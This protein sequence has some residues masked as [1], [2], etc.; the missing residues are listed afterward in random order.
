MKRKY[1][2][3]PLLAGAVIMSACKDKSTTDTQ[4]SS[5]SDSSTGSSATAPAVPAPDPIK[6]SATPEKRAEK[7]GFAKHLPKTIVKYDGIF[8]GKEAFQEFLKTPIGAFVLQRMADEGVSLEELMESGPAAGQIAQY[9]EEYF[10]AYGSGTGETFDLAM[11]L[12]NRFAYYGGRTGVHMADGF[13]REGDAYQPRGPEE[14][15]NGPLKGAPKEIV[16]MFQSFNMPAVYQGAK[17]SDAEA[18]ELVVEQMEQITSLFGMVE[19]I[20]EAITIKRGE[21][22]FNGFKISGAKIAE[23]IDEDDMEEMQEVFEAEDVSAFRDAL[24]KKSIICV[25]GTVGDYV[26]LF[27]GKSEDDFVL[28]ESVSDSMCANEE[29][30]FLDTYLDKKIIS[31]GYSDSKVVEM[32]GNLEAVGFRLLNS[33]TKGLGD[34]L[35]DAGSLGDT[36]DIEALLGSITEQGEKLVGMFN[37]ADL[38]YVVYIEDGLK[39]EGFG[40][41]NMPSI[42]FSKEHSL[43]SLGDGDNTLLFA[44]WTSN[45]AYNEA[46]MEYIDSVGE[47]AYLLTKRVA[48]LDIDDGDFRDFKQGVEMFDKAFQSDAVELWKALRGD[49]AAGLGAESALVMDVNGALPKIPNVPDVILKEG[50]MPRIGYVSTVDDRAKLQSSW[51][52]VNTSAENIL[53]TISEM[54]GE[55]IPMQV[56]MSSEKDGLKTWFVPIPFQN[57]D[58]VPSVSVSDEL[59]FVSTSKTFSEGLAERFKTGSKSGRK[60]AWLHVDFKVLNGFAKQWLALVEKNVE[61]IIPN[62]SGRADFTENKPMIDEALKVFGSLDTLTLN[63]RKE[64]GRTRVSLHLKT[65]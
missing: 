62:E 48:A 37:A 65:Q 19:E 46:V 14:F 50:K 17:V 57:D 21:N 35:G 60:G 36:Q 12:L 3:V 53:K 18:R 40:G 16:K 9:S 10:T 11:N 7:L 43:A 64:G 30:V 47:T 2:L 49:L 24:S 44:N 20:S 51:T 27:L 6:P 31:L 23:E 38:G 42:D 26:I 5:T 1:F 25:S 39:A 4:D 54:A 15:M 28:A 34:G 58:F 8:N 63:A 41:G 55:E 22:E 33:F 13:V 61:E 29:I 56:P 32:T 45:E 59:F 52:R